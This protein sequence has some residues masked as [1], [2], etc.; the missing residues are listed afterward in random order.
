MEINQ[1]GSY[2]CFINVKIVEINDK[3]VVIED[4]QGNKKEVYKDLFLQNFTP[5]SSNSDYTKSKSCANCDNLY[6][7]GDVR[8]HPEWHCEKHDFA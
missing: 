6:Q 2:G 1:I 4:K 7:C 3:T 8:K 5:S